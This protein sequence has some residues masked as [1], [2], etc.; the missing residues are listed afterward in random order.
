MTPWDIL[1]STLGTRN[2]KNKPKK[3]RC[4]QET[5]EDI[6]VLPLW[7]KKGKQVFFFFARLQAGQNKFPSL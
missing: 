5:A 6:L 2:L 3:K 1:R 4:F 7:E